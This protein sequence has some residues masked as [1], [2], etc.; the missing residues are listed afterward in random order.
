M[1]RPVG[2]GTGGHKG[3]GDPRGARWRRWEPHI[4]TPGTAI[5]DGYGSTS[6]EMYL[7]ALE[8][9]SPTI[10]A[11]GVTDYL[12]TRRYRQVQ[13]AKAR[14]R[15]PEVSLLFCN[16]EMRLSIETKAGKGINLHI[17]V[18]PNDPEHVDQIERFLAKLTFHYGRDNFAC[19]ESDL[20]RLGRAHQSSITDDEAALKTGINQF[21]VDFRQ[22]R[23]MYEDTEWMQANTLIAVAGS[24]NDGTAGLQNDGM[25]FAALRK[26]IEAFAHVIFSATP[27]NIAF[28]RGDG[29]LGEADLEQQYRGSKPCL[30]GSDAHRLEKVAKPDDNRFCWIKGD[31]TFE[32][33]RQACT[34]P[35]LRASIGATPPTTDTPYSISS[36]ATPSLQWLLPE[37][38]LVNPG[39]V[40]IIGARGS[41]KTAL[42]DLIAHAGDSQFPSD[43][44]QSFVN[45]AHSFLGAAQVTATWS[46]GSQ[47]QRCIVDRPEELPEVH[48]LTQQFVDRLCSSVAES[49]E[50][51]DEIKR[52]VFLAHEPESRLGADDFDSLAQIQSSETQL[53]VQSLNERLDRLSRQIQ[54]ERAWYMRRASLERDLAKMS[55]ELTKTERARRD[56]V[57]PG[58]E[59]RAGYYSRL[60]SAIS[61]REQELQ[62][63][64]R[65]LQGYRKLRT[66]AGRY[67]TQVFAQLHTD[68]QRAFDDVPMSASDWEAFRPNF[69]GN[70]Y[71]VL[72]KKTAGHEHAL[73][74]V[75]LRSNQTP[76]VTSTTDELTACSLDALKQARVSVGE[77]IS[78]D[79]KNLQ[80]LRQLNQLHTTQDAKRRRVEEDLKRAQQSSERLSQILQERASLYGQFFDLIIEQCDILNQLYEPLAA[81]LQTAS[82]SA[83]KLRLRVTRSVDVDAWA[84]AGESLLDLRKHGHF[85]G[86]GALTEVAREALLPA[87]RDGSATEVVAAMETFRIRYDKAIIDQSAVEHGTDEYQQWVIDLGRWLYSTE[88]IRVHYT[89]EYEGVAITQLSPGTRGIVL[90]LL[91]LALDLEDSR[92]LLIDQPE[93]NLDPKSVYSELISLFSEARLRRQVIIVTHNANLVVNTDVDQ[94]IVASCIKR[95][96]GSPP[97]FHYA[98]GGLEDPAIRAQVCDILEGGE[99]AFRKRAKRLRLDIGR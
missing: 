73:Q 90:L 63:L 35:R 85:K 89:I 78:A 84:E 79:Q 68:L 23:Q 36:V 14:G 3:T 5:N 81:K 98:S 6:M 17:L 65:E 86:R 82:T 19:T 91:Y 67:A 2:P 64:S 8:S 46:D 66:E 33:L 18:A 60:S 49:D 29:A 87:W 38:L 9:A 62:Q 47:S 26:E 54:V 94:V 75:R 53:A 72:A 93:E 15:L 30:H 92:P 13:E 11:L 95:E 96:G 77:Q 34:E 51:L 59:K 7:A 48:Y 32:A 45:R 31:A 37:P 20:G 88:H 61:E 43:G 21:K 39:M 50:L 27:K 24:S 52:V 4:H 42:A 99:A 69:S 16:I 56:L 12:L 80:R 22:L 97:D 41:G 25:S 74:G 83:N 70:P 44:S 58:G 28:W 40:A 76:T 57:K 71:S 55:E 10:E 1:T